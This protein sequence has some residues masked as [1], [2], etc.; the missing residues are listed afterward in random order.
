MR[1]GKTDK[2]ISIHNERILAVIR[3]LEG[4]GFRDP[5]DV[6]VFEGFEGHYLINEINPRFGGGYPHAYYCGQN[7]MD[8]IVQNLA[9]NEI[10]EDIGN[11]EGG[12]VMMK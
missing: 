12:I 7:F 9:G 8:C 10:T 6:N 5:I 2:Y 1:S 3:N 4:I 11:Y